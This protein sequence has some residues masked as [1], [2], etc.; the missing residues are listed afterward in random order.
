MLD[1]WQPGQTWLVA[2]AAHASLLK[3][4]AW[5]SVTRKPRKGCAVLKLRRHGGPLWVT[6]AA[7]GGASCTSP[8]GSV[9]LERVS[10]SQKARA[11]AAKSSN[12]PRQEAQ[13]ALATTQKALDKAAAGSAQRQ[14]RFGGGH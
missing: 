2:L 12:L 7:G 11:H 9:V 10:H 1:K 14:L 5:Q 3:Q 6:I 8:C 13:K 4:S